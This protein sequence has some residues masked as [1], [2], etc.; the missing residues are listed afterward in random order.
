MNEKTKLFR[1]LARLAMQ[2]PEGIAWDVLISHDTSPLPVVFNIWVATPEQRKTIQ[3]IFELG[4]PL[5]AADGEEEHLYS[6]HI[7]LAIREV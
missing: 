5:W 4:L 7:T 6:R 1:A 2:I 3:A